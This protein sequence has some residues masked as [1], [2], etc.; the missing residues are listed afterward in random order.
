M[1]TGIFNCVEHN[2][3]DFHKDV[4]VIDNMY[5]EIIYVNHVSPIQFADSLPTPSFLDIQAIIRLWTASLE[6]E[7]V[8]ISLYLTCPPF[9]LHTSRLAIH[10]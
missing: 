8:S 6:D 5:F 9:V 3:T 10:Q 4:N 1:W 7:V 2:M